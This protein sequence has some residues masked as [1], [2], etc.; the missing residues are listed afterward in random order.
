M[1][2]PF[3]GASKAWLAMRSTMAERFMRLDARGF[4]QGLLNFPRGS[5]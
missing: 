2:Q 3:T 4:H 5:E 1:A